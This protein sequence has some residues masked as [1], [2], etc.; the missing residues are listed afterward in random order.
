MYLTA[1]NRTLVQKDIRLHVTM[2]TPVPPATAPPGLL[3][4]S[5]TSSRKPDHS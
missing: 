4:T 1:G 2:P 3:D 5:S